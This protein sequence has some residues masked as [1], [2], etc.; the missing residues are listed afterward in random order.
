MQ[1]VANSAA[2]VVL[3]WAVRAS[4]EEF[5]TSAARKNLGKYKGGFVG[6]VEQS[7]KDQSDSDKAVSRAL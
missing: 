6:R 1:I 3:S 4:S 7:L 5:D 2:S